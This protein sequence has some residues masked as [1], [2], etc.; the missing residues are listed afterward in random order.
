MQDEKSMP[1]AAAIRGAAFAAM[2]AAASPASAEI[3]FDAGAD[4]RIRQE[5][6][7][8]VP[9]LPGG[10]VLNGEVRGPFINHVRFR[11]RVWGEIRLLS[12]EAGEWRVYTRL[13]DEFRWCPEPYRNTHTFPDEV[14]PDNL[15][16][17]GKGVFDGF[18]DFTIGRQDI[19]GLYGLDHVFV[20]G[21]PGDGSRTIYA[22]VV[23]AK[24]HFTEV[25]SL[26]LFTLY[27]FDDSDVRW[28]TD[29]GKHRSLSGLG[30]GAE[31]DMDDW[32]V[33]AVWNSD[34]G[35]ALP[36]QLFIMQNAAHARIIIHAPGSALQA[37]CG[38]GRG[39]YRCYISIPGYGNSQ[40]PAKLFI[41]L[42]GLF[43]QHNIYRHDNRLLNIKIIFS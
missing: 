36:Y 12:E 24:L 2:L 3:D 9:G 30:G 17:E 37:L 41:Y 40:I 16:I 13:T 27:D 5:L 22:D 18:L 10:G 34:L 15:F 1:F 21:T 6:M 43:R 4:L 19:Y 35:E 11:P 8:N 38:Q 25:S 32:G 14:I 7:K 31:P 29:R 33:G 23:R 26:D 42:F 39:V 28:G 20:D